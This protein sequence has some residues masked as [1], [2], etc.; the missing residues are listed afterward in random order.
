[1]TEAQRYCG[2]T[3]AQILER[4]GQLPYAELVHRDNL[5]IIG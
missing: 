4:F 2:L 3:S 1:M 5:V